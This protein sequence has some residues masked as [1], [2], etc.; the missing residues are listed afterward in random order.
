[1]HKNSTSER[2]ECNHALLSLVRYGKIIQPYDSL[3]SLSTT[4]MNHPP[5]IS[6]LRI[7]KM[8]FFPKKNLLAAWLQNASPIKALFVIFTVA[9]LSA[10]KASNPIDPILAIGD[11]GATHL[12]WTSPH[13][14]VSHF[15]IYFST[16]EGTASEGQKIGPI[17]ESAQKRNGTYTHAGLVNG[18]TYYYVVTGMNLE[19]EESAPSIE[20][21]AT[22]VEAPEEAIN[23]RFLPMGL[24]DDVIHDYGTGLEWQR[25]SVG[26]TWNQMQQN[27]EGDRATYD[28]QTAN[29]LTAPGDFR[30]PTLYEL[31][32]LIYCSSAEVYGM[33]RRLCD[34][35]SAQPAIV[36]EAFPNSTPDSTTGW[37]WT[38]TVV[39]PGSSYNVGFYGGVYDHVQYH[40]M[41][42]GV[43][44]VREA[45]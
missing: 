28:W 4:Y 6:I 25:C 38:S 24:N 41:P 45:Q 8:D 39:L 20:V 5:N 17:P 33:G 9:L 27:C 19:G 3:A 31:Q 32:T 40:I 15:Y 22:P 29:G 42:S 30:L 44:L 23:G 21:S 13:Q 16:L 34:D 26:Q 37:T 1:M 36:E 11:D 18:V 43:R 10:C 12:K 2:I 7:D 14:D 35:N